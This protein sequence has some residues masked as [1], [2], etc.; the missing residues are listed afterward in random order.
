MAWVA[1][2]ALAVACIAPAQC[3]CWCYLEQE[4]AAG[5]QLNAL[6]WLDLHQTGSPDPEQRSHPPSAAGRCG[7]YTRGQILMCMTLAL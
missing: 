1:A 3:H 5:S 4:G 7:T 6:L 2:V